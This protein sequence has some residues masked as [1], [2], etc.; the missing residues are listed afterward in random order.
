MKKNEQ[1]YFNGEMK[2]TELEVQL[3]EHVREYV[4]HRTAP[5]EKEGP[6]LLNRFARMKSDHDKLFTLL[7]EMV[8]SSLTAL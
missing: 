2:L 3:I 6:L 4:K 7:C 8:R 1:T 5:L